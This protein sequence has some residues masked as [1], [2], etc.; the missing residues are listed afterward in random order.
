[1]V[2]KNYKSVSYVYIYIFIILNLFPTYY[3]I[4]LSVMNLITQKMYVCFNLDSYNIYTRLQNN[5]LL[6]NFK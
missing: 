4:N 6:D 1:M 5:Y 3:D 2:K